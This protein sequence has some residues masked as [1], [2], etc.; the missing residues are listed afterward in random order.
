[1]PDHSQRN[2]AE[3]LDVV[4]QRL[5]LEQ[6]SRRRVHAEPAIARCPDRPI[7]GAVVVGSLSVRQVWIRKTKRPSGDGLWGAYEVCR[8]EHGVWLYTPQGSRYRGTSPDGSVGECFVGRPEPPGMDVLQL[9]PS[10]DAWWFGHWTAVGGRHGL[11]ID[12]C[13]PAVLTGDEWVYID[14]ELDLSKSSDGTIRV[15]DQDEFDEAV[16]RQLISDPERRACLATVAALEARL[17]I[18]DHVLDDLALARLGESTQ[19]GV[20][21]ITDFS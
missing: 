9:V 4:S 18:H 11:A 19:L 3:V 15:Y 13:R 10:E 8:D 6:Q 14:L 21:P 5:L 2:R 1:V 17:A 7:A 16:S 12:V 20:P